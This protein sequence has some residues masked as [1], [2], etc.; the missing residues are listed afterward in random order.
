M[1]LA[2]LIGAITGVVVIAVILITVVFKTASD[3]LE[4]NEQAFRKAC[5]AVNGAAVWNSRYW[6]CLK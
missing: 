2:V 5:T 3:Q 6:E 4:R 1:K